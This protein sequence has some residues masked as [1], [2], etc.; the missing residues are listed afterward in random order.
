MNYDH[1]FPSR[2][3]AIRFS[4]YHNNVTS[5]QYRIQTINQKLSIQ[6]SVLREGSK[7]ESGETHT[8]DVDSDY[9]LNRFGA[10]VVWE[11]RRCASVRW[12]VR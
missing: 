7:M 3:L 12:W 1:T 8:N 10:D 5:S 6:N 9:T 2:S 4:A 11:Q